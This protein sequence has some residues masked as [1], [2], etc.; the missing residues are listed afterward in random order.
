MQGQLA[1]IIQQQ[2]AALQ[3]QLGGVITD[4]PQLY[5]ALLDWSRAGLID[6]GERYWIN[7]ASPESQQRQQQKQQETQQQQQQ[8][9]QIAGMAATAEQQAAQ[10]KA[11]QD[12]TEANQ[13]RQFNYWK[14]ALSA[15]VE[16]MKLAIPNEVDELQDFGMVK[17][18]TGEP[19]QQ[20][21]AQQNAGG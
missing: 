6:N 8:A 17:S 5:N 1:T 9:V 14:E 13:D 4:L 3:N 18:I 11:I 16:E 19:E 10:I 7:T 2:T 15:A 20:Q 12:Q 21:G